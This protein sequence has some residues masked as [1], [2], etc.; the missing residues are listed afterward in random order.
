MRLCNGLSV[1]L[2]RIRLGESTFEQ[3]GCYFQ[4]EVL[5]KLRV[6]V[7][8]IGVAFFGSLGVK[9]YGSVF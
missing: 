3:G 8:Q 4:R 9:S 2:L 5:K 1:F 7:Y 6:I